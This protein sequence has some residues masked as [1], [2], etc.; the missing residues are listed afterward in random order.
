MP[1]TNKMDDLLPQIL[2][3]IEVLNN[4]TTRLDERGKITAEHLNK[5]NKELD[6]ICE[7][8]NENKEKI[9]LIANECV[10]KADKN[11]ESIM[12][13]GKDEIDQRKEQID[14][15]KR[16]AKL[17]AMTSQSEGRWQKITNFAIQLIYALVTC[18]ILWKFGLGNVNSPP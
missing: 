9:A 4:L 1:G 7:M 14:L 17:E 11:E 3:S 15:E 6:A 8:A 13:L 18:Y 10:I 2:D 5:L 16:V 12:V